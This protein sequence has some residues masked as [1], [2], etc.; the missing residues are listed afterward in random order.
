MSALLILQNTSRTLKSWPQDFI[1]LLKIH[2]RSV[3]K[4]IER[5]LLIV[6]HTFILCLRFSKYVGIL[7]S[8][9]CST[10]L[11]F[12]WTLY[13]DYSRLN[14]LPSPILSELLNGTM[15][16]FRIIRIGSVLRRV[17]KKQIVFTLSIAKELTL[18]AGT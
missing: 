10:M 17:L 8:L 2:R 3:L 11:M 14:L 16:L 1:L 7:F 12:R 6:N 4:P 18:F 9:I 5:V 15:L 13:T